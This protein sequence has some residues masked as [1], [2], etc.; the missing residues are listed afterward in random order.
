MWQAAQFFSNDRLTSGGLR[1]SEHRALRPLLPRRPPGESDVIALAAIRHTLSGQHCLFDGMPAHWLR[2]ACTSISTNA[3]ADTNAA[4]WRVERSG[5]SVLPYTAGMLLARIGEQPGQA[6][7]IHV[8]LRR[9]K[10]RR[11]GY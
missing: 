5:L 3:P 4:T 10:I 6:P 9:R 7:Q 2:A 1:H 11:L 8:V